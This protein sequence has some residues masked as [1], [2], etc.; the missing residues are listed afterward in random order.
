MLAPGI[1]LC[2]DVLRCIRSLQILPV[3]PRIALLD[4]FTVDVPVAQVQDSHHA[5][6]AV[7]VHDLHLHLLVQNLALQG[8]VRFLTIGLTGL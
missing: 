7:N 5:A 4:H 1:I 3:G 8:S 6:I 2:A